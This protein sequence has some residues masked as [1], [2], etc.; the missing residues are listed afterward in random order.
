MTVRGFSCLDYAH[1]GR[2]VG[3]EAHPAP[4]SFVGSPSWSLARK[5]VAGSRCPSAP[6][7]LRSFPQRTTAGAF[8]LLSACAHTEATAGN[9]AVTVT[10]FMRTTN[11]VCGDV[12]IQ[13][14]ALS[15]TFG[16]LLSAAFGAAAAWIGGL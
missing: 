9:C 4:A 2:G 15:V 8:L 3:V 14:P 11:V 10:T 6:S 12:V 1:R 7:R 13:H 16:N 5:G